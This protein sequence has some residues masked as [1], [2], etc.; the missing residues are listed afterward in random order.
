MSL[1]SYFSGRADKRQDERLFAEKARLLIEAIQDGNLP[2]VTALHDEVKDDKRYLD[3]YEA[4]TVKAAVRR[5]DVAIFKK[6]FGGRDPNFFF[7]HKQVLAGHGGFMAEH[8]HVLRTAINERS[9][10]IAL[11]LIA[12]P[13]TN[14]DTPGYQMIVYGDQKKITPY[15]PSSREV[16][17]HLGMTKV[18]EALAKRG[19]KPFSILKP[20]K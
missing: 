18:A 8:E 20:F 16:A 13:L 7:V 1:R 6:V 5:D 4:A 14:V 3:H 15:T 12:N 2:L 17:Q 19:N 11:L 10:N 9:A